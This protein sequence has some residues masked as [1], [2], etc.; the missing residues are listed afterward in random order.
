MPS[1][2]VID[3]DAFEAAH[4][5]TGGPQSG[6]TRLLS[7]IARELSCAQGQKVLV[8]AATP[9]G[10]RD[11]ARRIHMQLADDGARPP[12]EV[13][14]ARD[15]ALRVVADPAARKLHGRKPRLLDPF[16]EH[17]LFED[18]RTSRIKERR[19][20]EVLTFLCGGLANLSDDDPNWLVTQEEESL[21]SLLRDNL[22]F[23]GGMLASELG[24]FAV[25]ALRAD[26]DLRKRHGAD[27]VLVDDFLK[28]DRAT[29]HLTRLLAAQSLTC[30]ASLAPES[31]AACEFPCASGIDELRAQ[32]PDMRLT[33]LES[34]LQP[35]SA[36][37]ASDTLAPPDARV[38]MLGTMADE[39][40]AIAQIS[41]KAIREGRSVMIVS[42]HPLWRKNA[43][44]NL[45]AASVPLAHASL[46]VDLKDFRNPAACARARQITLERLA[47]DP[48]DGVAWR[49]LVGF[50]DY[51]ARSAALEDVR[52]EACLCGLG[53]EEAL[54][55]LAKDASGNA[56]DDPL[57]SALASAFAQ[58]C[59]DLD[60]FKLSERQAA[61]ERKSANREVRETCEV[62]ICSPREA[63]CRQADVVIFASF[64][65]GIV[66][67]KSACARTA[68]LKRAERDLRTV[69]GRARQTLI[70]TGFET[71]SL[72][73]AELLNLGIERI[74]LQRSARQ[75]HIAPSP[76][77]P[78]STQATT[79]TN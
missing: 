50:G 36:C 61:S 60:A 73:A 39:L 35:L 62:R 37:C 75:A 40:R 30:A 26:A 20:R 28:L 58:G 18:L 25:K 29:Q 16:E 1:T 4:C 13:A 57:R 59:R 56:C 9:E 71:C 22:H 68:E 78:A 24:N 63:A 17:F 33:T 74:K 51:V 48:H 72:E 23:T 5:I 38:I 34:P 21:L 52:R 67:K 6:K 12:I 66:P 10:A 8:L 76:L 79:K 7:E 2:P 3:H 11:M 44:K 31:P 19:L 32:H 55:E 47:K 45:S 27:H 42:P 53:I 43:R 14:C 64:V 54:L 70:I 65:D 41:L 77:L 49:S 69:A 15:W 46:P